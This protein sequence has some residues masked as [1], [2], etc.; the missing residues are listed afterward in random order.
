MRM[1]IIYDDNPNLNKPSNIKR[2]W[3]FGDNMEV[4]NIMSRRKQKGK[5]F[6]NCQKEGHFAAK[7]S[8]KLRKSNK[9]VGFD[10]L[11]I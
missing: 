6:F 1:A 11:K 10:V 9:Q 2:T 7:C 5:L 8:K 4:D 3:K